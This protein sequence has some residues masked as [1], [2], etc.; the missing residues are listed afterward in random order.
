MRCDAVEKALVERETGLLSPEKTKA[1][2]DHLAACPACRAGAEVERRITADLALLGALPAPEVEIRSRVS[3]EIG[4]MEAVDRSPVP[5]GDLGWAGAA[6]M[7]LAAAVLVP[8]LWLLPELPGAARQVWA[9]A[10]GLGSAAKNVLAPFEPVLDVFGQI[11]GVVL[12]TLGHF[13]PLAGV[14]G[15]VAL[16]A[17]LLAILLM[18]GVTTYVVGRDFFRGPQALAKE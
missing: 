16:A 17:T 8:G 3:G 11:A 6:A 13:A 14:I 9:L 12:D 1:L 4:A 15:Q 5:L 18:T 10:G 7:V 2:D